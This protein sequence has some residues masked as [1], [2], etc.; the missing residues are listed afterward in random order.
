MKRSP[1]I[2]CVPYLNA[3]PLIYGHGR[4]VRMLP[5]AQLA[6]ELALGTLDAALSPVFGWLQAPTA[7]VGV[8]GVAI[9]CCGPVH[10]VILVHA[11]PLRELQRIRLDPASRSSANLLRVLLAEFHG[12]RPEFSIWDARE[13]RLLAPPASREGVL[14]IGDGANAFRA[15]HGE[16]IPLLDLGSAWLAATG[17]PFVF[18]VWLIRAGTPHPRV[19]A[20]KLRAWREANRDRIAT[21]AACHAPQEKAFARFY[22]RERI[23]FD[24]EDREKRG[25]LEYG[26]LLA[27]HRLIEEAPRRLRWV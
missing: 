10:S 21:I 23:R 17:L 5:P 22:L 6:D 13:A 2:G 7:F 24:L 16:R 20:Q 26:R 4:E 11:G 19:L 25:L 1:R 15:R 3:K 14:M 18:A 12:V 8:D 9:S 27:R